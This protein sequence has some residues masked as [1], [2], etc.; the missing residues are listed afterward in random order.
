MLG[1]MLKQSWSVSVYNNTLI[2]V[3]GDSDIRG[4]AEASASL[5]RLTKQTDAV[6]LI[7]ILCGKMKLPSAQFREASANLLAEHKGTLRANALVVEEVGL[8]GTAL[9]SVLTGLSLV[10]R[11]EGHMKVFKSINDAAVWTAPHAKSEH[12]ELVN[13]CRACRAQVTG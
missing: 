12:F 9:R 6:C 2:T 11:Y 7:A 5:L 10:A 1:T 13:A 3:W 4:V 8:T